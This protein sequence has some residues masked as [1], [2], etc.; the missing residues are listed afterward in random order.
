MISCM[1]GWC[2]KRDKCAHYEWRSV[3]VERLCETDECF[4]PLGHAD[5]DRGT[6]SE[7]RGRQLA[8]ALSSLQSPTWNRICEDLVARNNKGH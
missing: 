4:I 8:Q 2:L 1:G 6:S 7:M 5:L 3:F